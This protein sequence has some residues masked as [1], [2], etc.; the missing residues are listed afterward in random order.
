MKN[1]RAGA[2]GCKSSLE[3]GADA[4]WPSDGYSGRRISMSIVYLCLC[5]RRHFVG[6][7]GFLRVVNHFGPS[8]D[9]DRQGFLL[10]SSSSSSQ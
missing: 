2:S 10:V 8:F 7:V 1:V 4:N 9:G 5:N 6:H 3:M